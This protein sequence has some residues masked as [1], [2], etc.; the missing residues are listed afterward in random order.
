MFMTATHPTVERL[1]AFLSKSGIARADFLR[2]NNITTQRYNNWRNRGIPHSEMDKIALKVGMSFNYLKYGKGT[3]DDAGTVDMSVSD[4]L[5]AYEVNGLNIAALDRGNKPEKTL[6]IRRV[7]VLNKEQINAGIKPESL[8]NDEVEWAYA[9][10][11]SQA[12]FAIKTSEIVNPSERY[13]FPDNSIIIIDPSADIENGKPALILDINQNLMIRR[14]EKIGGQTYLASI[15]QQ[16]A[17]IQLT[18]VMKIIG[19][20]KSVNLEY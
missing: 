7:P 6:K 8:S 19:P 1:E 20:V 11:I 5:G 16:Y 10:K 2:N 9:T 3:M 17:P 14:I 4:S 18:E 12:A 13:G 15:N